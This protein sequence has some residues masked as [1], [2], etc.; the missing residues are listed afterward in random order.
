MANAINQNL[1]KLIIVPGHAVYTGTE[2]RHALQTTH[3]RGTFPGYCDNDEAELYTEH[4]RVGVEMASHSENQQSL[5][6]FSGGQTRQAAG[7]YSEAQSYWRLADQFD[8]FGHK[9]VR[10][11][12]TTEEYARDSFEN[13][14]FA[15]YRFHQCTGKPPTD[16]LV[17]GFAFKSKRY[18]DH[19][20]T[21][22]SNS[23]SRVI[24]EEM[25][26]KYLGVNNPP[27]YMLNGENGSLT[28]EQLTR[29][30]FS[31]DPLGTGEILSTKRLI[32][33]PFVRGNPY[34]GWNLL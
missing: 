29:S 20:K 10:E 31:R 11:R 15:L 28:G 19:Y 13:L 27:D 22:L 30:L 21:I 32:R 4:I 9:G 18:H 5:L 7:P 1:T 26:F 12:A 25:K 3:W 6:V 2:I 17:C 24:G 33:D 14:L 16:V 34:P 8:W 23:D